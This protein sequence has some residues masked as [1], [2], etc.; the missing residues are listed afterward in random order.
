M[1]SNGRTRGPATDDLIRVFTGTGTIVMANENVLCV[2]KTVGAASAVTLPPQAT[3]AIGRKIWIVDSKGDAGTNNITISP[4][5]GTLNGASNYVISENYGAVELIYNGTEWNAV[6][7]F[8][9]VSAAEIGFLNGVTAGTVSASKAVVVDA[10]KNITGFGNVSMANLTSSGLVTFSDVAPLAA[11]GTV[12][13]NAAAIV[14]QFSNVS[15]ANST[16]GVQLPASLTGIEYTVYNSVSAQTLK[17]Y[18][19]TNGTIQ[20]GSANA[21]FTQSGLTVSTFYALDNSNNW[22]VTKGG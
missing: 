5:A 16:A 19:Q 8:N 9:A 17:V 15:G 3:G 10:S 7:Y 4:A 1:A 11:T 6:A 21:A 18:P 20:G 2:N 14:H 22:A 13:T 12:I